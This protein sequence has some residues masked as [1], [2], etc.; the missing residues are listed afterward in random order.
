MTFA[1]NPTIKSTA[2]FTAPGTIEGAP[3][4]QSQ[5]AVASLNPQT[6][7]HKQ[8]EKFAQT[9]LPTFQPGVRQ[10][11]TSPVNSRQ[12]VAPK[13]TSTADNFAYINTLAALNLYSNP[14]EVDEEIQG[15][16]AMARS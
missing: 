12:T 1:Q 16:Y 11:V 6:A 10:N 8:P 9:A 5:V 14:V 2:G 7:A 13:R 4:P 15:L 3:A